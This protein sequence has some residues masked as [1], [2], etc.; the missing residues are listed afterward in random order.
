MNIEHDHQ[1]VVSGNLQLIYPR[2]IAS[3]FHSVLKYCDKPKLLNQFL[4]VVKFMFNGL[5]R[6]AE[7]GYE[8]L[9]EYSGQTGNK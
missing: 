2:S 1:V 4:P 6:E 5:K 3:V 8:T 7:L 9:C